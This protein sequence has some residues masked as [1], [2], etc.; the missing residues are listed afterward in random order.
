MYLTVPSVVQTTLDVTLVVTLAV[1]V[2]AGA[3][4]RVEAVPVEMWDSQ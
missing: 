2:F 3:V 4:L 1:I